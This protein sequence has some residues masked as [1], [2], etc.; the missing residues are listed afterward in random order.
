MDRDRLLDSPGAAQECGPLLVSGTIAAGPR[1]QSATGQGYRGEEGRKPQWARRT[2]SLQL[3]EGRDHS[4]RTRACPHPRRSDTAADGGRGRRPPRTARVNSGRERVDTR[5]NAVPAGAAFGC[6]HRGGWETGPRR[7]PR[8][9][10]AAPPDRGALA[11]RP[12]AARA[13]SGTSRPAAYAA[14]PVAGL[15]GALVPASGPTWPTAY[16]DAAPPPWGHPFR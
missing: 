16:G 9:P 5:W 2:I 14:H 1:Q 12:F 10:T 7:R 3:R 11:R 4:S 15:H 6:W 13:R 8:A